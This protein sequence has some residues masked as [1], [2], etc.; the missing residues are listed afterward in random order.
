MTAL[1]A[2]A[3]SR[4]RID[5]D[6]ETRLR[7]IEVGYRMLSRRL[8]ARQIASFYGISRRTAYNW[9]ALALTYAD[10]EADELRRKAAEQRRR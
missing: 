8:C 3:V 4:P 2:V 5:P 9:L 7:H 10:P 6:R 1:C